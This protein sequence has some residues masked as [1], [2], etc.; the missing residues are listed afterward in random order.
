MWVKIGNGKNNTKVKKAK[1]V[2]M[3]NITKL[4]IIWTSKKKVT[5]YLF[6][7]WKKTHNYLT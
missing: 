6:Q 2:K 7:E 3:N 5:N 1:I 4:K